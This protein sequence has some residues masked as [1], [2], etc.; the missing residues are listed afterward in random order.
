M[1]DKVP[2]GEYEPRVP[3]EEGLRRIVPERS[4]ASV[5]PALED[6]GRA[7]EQVAQSDAANY[8]STTLSKAQA[9]WTQ[10]LIDRQQSAAPGAPGFTPGFMADYGKYADQAAKDAPT[11]LA[12]HVLSHG[13]QELGSQLNQKAMLFEAGERQ[14]NNVDVANQSIDS[15]GN[16]L[17][18]DPT[19]FEQRLGQRTTLI[20]QMNLDPNVKEQLQQHASES[21]AKFATMGDIQRDPYKAMLEL[22]STDPGNTYTKLLPPEMKVQLLAHADEQLHQRVADNERIEAMADKKERQNA[23][24]ALSSLI[25]QSQSAQ[26]VTMADVMKKAPLFSHDPS[27]LEAAMRIASGKE[28]ETDVHT[29]LPLLQ[30]AIAGQDVSEE[31]LRDA[32]R[33]LSKEDATRLL[34]LGDKGLPTAAKQGAATVDGAFHQDFV[35][36]YDDA[37]NRRHMNALNDYYEWVRQNPTASPAAA[38]DQANKIATS[39]SMAHLAEFQAKTALPTFAVGGRFQMNPDATEAATVQAEAQHKISHDEAMKQAALIQQ[40]RSNVERLHGVAH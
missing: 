20:G 31:V 24:G 26:G 28:V 2:I 32:G 30:S 16:E 9:D 22:S 6:L 10:H 21:M 37:F 1:A 38:V 14:K 39:Y 33:S 12:G 27:G 15:A 18:H 40:W 4:G 17:M 35:T 36:K 25:V 34:Q 29:Y 13:L 7:T 23:T 11:G 8:A 5:G 3:V 19:V